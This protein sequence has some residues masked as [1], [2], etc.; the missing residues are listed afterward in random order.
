MALASVPC[1][2]HRPT[3]IASQRPTPR[4]AAPLPSAPARP[5]VAAA[6]RASHCAAQRPGRGPAAAEPQTQ[7][8]VPTQTQ[9]Q[10]DGA[11]W[12]TVE[13][14]P[15]TRDE[16]ASLRAAL[17]PGAAAPEGRGAALA[18]L[19][20]AGIAKGAKDLSALEGA[21]LAAEQ[22]SLG[23]LQL[24]GAAAAAAPRPLEGAGSARDTAVWQPIFA[25]AGG[26]PRLLYIPVPE[27][28]DLSASEGSAASQAAAL[29]RLTPSP[30]PAGAGGAAG[31][32][33]GG[34]T[35]G[36]YA[37]DLGAV[38]VVTEMGPVTTHF[39][40]PCLW[41][42]GSTFEYW[43]ESCRVEI[44]AWKV[45][46]TIP[47]RLH[48]ALTFFYVDPAAGLACARSRLGGTMLLAAEP[49]GGAK[50]ARG[51]GGAPRAR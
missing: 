17:A 14:K 43:V 41:V 31:G 4:G 7:Q 24:G 20:R 25:S 13:G 50:Y 18:E 15:L 2:F 10:L 44:P 49:P 32:T 40:G 27:Y 19:I 37:G 12:M 48:N 3:M 23:A 36:R 11:A 5:C 26:F 34:V 47:F 6:R 39:L 42:D 38:D 28:F 9:Q 22:V 45:K 33:A 29:R 46:F 30:P 51:G 1:A 35:S 8:Q 21:I 16:A